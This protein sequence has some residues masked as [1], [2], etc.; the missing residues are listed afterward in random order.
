M[1]IP[2]MWPYFLTQMVNMT[3]NN[4]IMGAEGQR[5]F[6]KFLETLDT[7]FILVVEGVRGTC[8]G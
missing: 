1:L 4:S 2:Q 3:Y 8:R 7:E 6:E 5:A